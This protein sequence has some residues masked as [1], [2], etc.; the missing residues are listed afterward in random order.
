[1]NIAEIYKMLRD[2]AVADT[3]SGGLFNASSAFKLSDWYTAVANRSATAPYVVQSIASAV[4]EDTFWSEV[5]PI[6]VRFAV[7]TAIEDGLDK[8]SAI[9]RRIY[10]DATQTG[11]I[12]H[13]FHRWVP[14][15]TSSY[16]WS[17][18]A[19]RYVST[20]ENHDDDWFCF[21][22]EYEFVLTR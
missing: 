16:G 3:G 13:G 7:W 15:L 22:P 1:M 8:P 14:T 17:A 9:M 21:I 12:T 10:G 2:R 19:M 6:R 5:V 20:A 11:S 18:T 4:A